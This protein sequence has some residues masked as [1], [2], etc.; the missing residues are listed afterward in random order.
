MAKKASPSTAQ[1][2]DTILQDARAGNFKP[3]YYLMGEESYYIDF[4][5]DSLIDLALDPLD[6]DFNLITLFGPD[7]NAA[8]IV[9]VARGFPMGAMRLVVVVR[10]AQHIKDLAPLEFYLHQPQPSTIL[11]ICHKNGRIDKRVKVAGLIE[12]Q[13]VLF[14][15]PKLQWESQLTSFITAYLRSKDVTI[16][17][18]AT[19]MMAE[20]VGFDLHR[21]AGELD[22]LIIALAGKA[23][24]ITRNLVADNVG[25]S[26]EFNT[27]ELRDALAVKNVEKVMKI[28]N[29]FDKNSK[30]YPP[31]KILPGIFSFFSSLML[32]HYS[33]DKSI[34]GIAAHLGM[35]EFPVKMTI[36][37]ALRLYT[38]TK[39]MHIIAAIRR[40]D[41]RLKG[42]GESAGSA[43]DIM[44]ELY[45]FIL[46][47]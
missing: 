41:A 5:A 8:Q 10:E 21:M 39:V 27:F 13:G 47:D 44:K 29:Y 25:I 26:R 40:T 6:R 4:L 24:H 30:A 1:L 34:P 17:P 2:C 42:I 19:L 12:K 46:H 38:A 20:H 43:G 3:V 28:A 7:T 9:D 15:S 31:Q 33:P 45:F 37:P 11:I 32:A 22:K 23:Q 36:A 18:D 14:E 35:K 16:E